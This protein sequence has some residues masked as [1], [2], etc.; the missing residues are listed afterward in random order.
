[1]SIYTLT[2]QNNID[3]FQRFSSP[4]LKQGRILKIL[5]V[6]VEI[7]KATTGYLNDND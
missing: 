7:S 5:T 4:G 1:L 3:G 2:K 6:A